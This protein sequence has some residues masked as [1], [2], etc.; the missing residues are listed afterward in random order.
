LIRLLAPQAARVVERRVGEG[1]SVRAGEVVFVLS[2]DRESRGG[3]TQERIARGLAQRQDSVAESL[4][5]ERRLFNEQDSALVRR[6]GEA[7][8]ELAELDAE[9]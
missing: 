5:T 2:L 9:L 3:E 4:R 1:A 7:R 6:L 8:R